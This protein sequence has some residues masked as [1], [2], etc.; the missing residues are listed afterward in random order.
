MEPITGTAALIG[1]LGLGWLFSKNSESKSEGFEN[2]AATILPGADRTPAGAPTVPGLP[3][4]ANYTP[5]G[6]Y[7][8]QQ[9]LPSL[10][11]FAREPYLSPN[12]GGSLHFPVP[13]PTLPDQWSG[14]SGDLLQ[15]RPD[16][17]EDATDRPA[18]VSP[19]TGIEF[20]QGE[21]KH[22]NMVP[23]FRG[24]LKQNS[25]DS[26]NNQVLDSYTGA[27][28]T[29]FAKREQTPF[30]EPTKEPIGNPY[31]MEA[32]T[33]FLQSRY[34]EPK[35]R[36]GERPVEPIRVGKGLDD[37]FTELPSGGFQQ[38][39]GEEFML[40]R[41]A[42]TDDLRTAN[43]PKLSYY[44]PVVPGAAV[45]TAPT[46]PEDIG[47]VR[48]YQ[49]D[50]FYINEKGERNF[51]TVGADQ[52]ATVRSV[53]IVRNTTRPDTSK[54]YEGIA[55]QAEGKATYTIGST[56]TPLAKQM[57]TW[58][59]RNAD[60]TTNF[61]PDTDAQENDYGKS[62]VEI[63]PNE[64]FYTG[65][66]VMGLNVVPD[67]REVTLPQQDFV[68]PTRAE[69][70]IDLNRV[71]VAGPADAQ[72]KLTVY[73]PNDVARTTIRET[74]EDNGYI[75]IEA[76]ADCAQKLTVYDPDD[77]MKVTGRNTLDDWDWYRNL[78]RQDTPGAAEI[79]LQ[80]AVRNTQKAALSA[81]SAYTGTA[82]LASG[83]A[84]KDQTDARNMRQYA[85][86]ENIARGRTPMGSSVKLFNAE[87]NINITY[88]KLNTDIV[89]D[90]ENN[91]DRVAN[92][93]SSTE[94]LGVQRPRTVLKLDVSAVRNAPIF[95][96]S[97][98]NNPYVIPLHK[99][100][101]VGGKNAI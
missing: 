59:F 45:V 23:F 95:V 74:T 43:N 84:E 38:T 24:Q 65:E 37:G 15:M 82:I 51:V 58:G 34:V 2:S 101:L 64:R 5:S 17:W 14:G 27:S 30:F 22:A 31:G 35:N 62:G 4:T 25:L 48:K 70:T 67:E 40:R 63:R 61:N 9:P 94:V 53:Q 6:V 49:P 86:R 97:L 26:A 78:G 10:G 21:F 96:A 91:V 71:G 88:R 36:G 89:N 7:D 3:R 90:R 85:Q 46:A 16:R 42:R 29:L 19:L 66:R 83:K 68:R 76:P 93:P 20:K 12:Q 77:I 75:G 52:K 11:S 56:R 69:E 55:G 73:D 99:S 87:D 33:D 28:K 98:E 13:A 32:A 81:K 39:A 54:P 8:I 41:M 1:T 92:L 47:E 60:L 72:P 100:A 57:G 50:K 79:R 44:Q 18:F 80:D